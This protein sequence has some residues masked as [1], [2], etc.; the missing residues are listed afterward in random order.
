[1]NRKF[2]SSSR[3]LRTYTLLW[4]LLAASLCTANPLCDLAEKWTLLNERLEQ[5][6][7]VLGQKLGAKLTGDPAI[8]AHP[9][10]QNHPN[11]LT[12]K[13]AAQEKIDEALGAAE[14]AAPGLVGDLAAS[15]FIEVTTTSRVVSSSISFDDMGRG[16]GH[17]ANSANTAGIANADECLS[18]VFQKQRVR[19][20]SLRIQRRP[21][22]HI[23]G[24][25]IP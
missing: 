6:G 1:M 20:E 9:R 13:M 16:F 24:S 17:M 10:F 11:G 4:T 23:H 12:P 5:E 25:L 15:E 18:L 21:E 3:M 8:A 19:F 2:L 14:A 7:L 22:L